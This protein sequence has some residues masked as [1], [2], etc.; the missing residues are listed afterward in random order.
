MTFGLAIVAVIAIVGFG[1][2]GWS[3]VVVATGVGFVV[4]GV[5]DDG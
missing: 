4:G 5:D 1:V 3:L 2:V